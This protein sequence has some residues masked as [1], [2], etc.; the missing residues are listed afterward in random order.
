MRQIYSRTRGFPCPFCHQ[1]FKS[2]SGLTQHKS[3]CSKNPD[4]HANICNPPSFTLP[5]QSPSR[6]PQRT[7]DLFRQDQHFGFSPRTPVSFLQD[8]H[9]DFLPYTPAPHISNNPPN[10]DSPRRIRW[11]E[12][13][14]AK[15][16]IHP[17]LNGEL[18]MYPIEMI[19]IHL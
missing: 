18:F 13:G 8:E 2:P 19:L 16:R 6:T 1:H 11:T 3:T 17:Y 5:S 15:I 14:R 7:P 10:H 12:K 9:F 4:Y